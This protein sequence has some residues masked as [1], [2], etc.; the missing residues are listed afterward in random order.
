MPTPPSLASL[1]QQFLLT[2]YQQQPLCADLFSPA[3]LSPTLFTTVAERLSI[4]IHNTQL[5]LLDLLRSSYP[6]IEKIVGADFFQTLAFHYQK[7]Y[8]LSSGDRHSFGA[9]LPDFIANFPPASSLV[10]LSELA[11][12]EWWHHHA[13]FA[14]NATTLTFEQ[15]QQQ[16]STGHDVRLPLHPSV[17]C[18]SVHYNVLDIWQAHQTETVD[19][20]MLRC[21]QNDLLIWRN[22]Q[23]EL[24]IHPISHDLFEFL[25]RC[26]DSFFNALPLSTHA[27]FQTEFAFCMTQG[28]FIEENI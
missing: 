25:N 11:Q 8:P 12:L 6:V 17:R 28:I 2:L 26:P 13:Y 7:H 3:L 21:E 14:D 10:Y 16:L 19:T 15:L 27:A 23:H 24:L 4:Y 22:H 9:Q 5:T 18:L 1:Q 20:L